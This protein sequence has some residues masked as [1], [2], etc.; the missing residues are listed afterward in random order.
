MGAPNRINSENLV[1]AYT[2]TGVL[3]SGLMPN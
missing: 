1:A 2:T 3:R